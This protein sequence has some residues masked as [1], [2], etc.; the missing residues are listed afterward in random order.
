MVLQ[1]IRQYVFTTTW[2]GLGL[3]LALLAAVLD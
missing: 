2:L 3:G 1:V